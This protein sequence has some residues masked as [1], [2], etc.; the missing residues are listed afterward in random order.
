V[1]SHALR[2]VQVSGHEVKP[3]KRPGRALGVLAAT[4]LLLTA[5][6]T[7]EKSKSNACNVAATI[8]GWFGTQPSAEHVEDCG[9]V[10]GQSARARSK[11][12]D[13]LVVDRSTVLD[14]QRRLRKMGYDP[15]PA[16]GGM[17]PKTRAAIRAYQKDAGLKADGRLTV[18]LVK[19][20]RR[21]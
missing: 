6:C 17:G 8:D 10:A 7:M 20:I 11:Y 2:E 12:S 18:G 3:A 13:G 14:V 5:A 21:S 4:M 16:D 19:R 9:G 15:G 1:A